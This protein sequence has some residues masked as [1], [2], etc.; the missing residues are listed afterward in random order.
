VHQ[1]DGGGAPH[2][3]S[4]E[5]CHASPA[6]LF[7]AT[8]FNLIVFTQHLIL[9]EYLIRSV[10]L[11]AATAGALIVG[12]AVLIADRMP[13]LRGSDNAPLTQPTLFK[14]TIYWAVVFVVRLIEITI[15]FTVAQPESG[16][17]AST[18]ATYFAWDRFLFVQIW[19]LVPFPIYTTAFELNVLFGDG[20]V[21]RLLFT[22]RSSGLKQTRRQRIRALVR[23]ARV[24][25][26]HTL[27]ELADPTSAPHRIIVML[28]S[29]L[30]QDHAARQ[31]GPDGVASR[32]L[33]KPQG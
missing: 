33:A 3:S 1:A 25:E 21:Y 10:G 9:L 5:V 7:F 14:T 31:R 28:I 2:V 22:R 17:F 26:R 13:F 24:S 20:E 4:R 12:K 30:A 8:G 15:R 16:G 32:N 6:T 11:L 23:V 29:Q 19:I 27:A 18:L